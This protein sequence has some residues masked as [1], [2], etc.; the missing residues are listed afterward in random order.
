MRIAFLTPYLPYP[1]DT[2]GKIRTFHILKELASHHEVHVIT[3]HGDPAAHT[4]EGI[5]ELGA[6]VQHFPLNKVY[7]PFYQLHRAL[8]ATPNHVAAFISPSAL[9]NVSK[10]LRTVRFDVVFA[11]EVVMTPYVNTARCPVRILA[12]QNVDYQLRL[13]AASKQRFG[14]RK[15]QTLYEYFR[16]KRFLE[17]VL[18]QDWDGVIICSPEDESV[19]TSIN[20]QTKTYVVPNG[21]DL[22]HFRPQPEP[23]GGPP[24]LLF[25]GS[26]FYYPNIDAVL[27]FFAKIYQRIRALLP[28]IRVLIVGHDP[29]SEIQRLQ[30]TF[31]N[32]QV[33]GSVPDVT[34]YFAESTLVIVPLRLGGGTSLKILEAMAMKRPVVTTSTG[35]RGLQLQAGK[36]LVVAD[37]PEIFAKEVVDLATNDQRRA[38]LIAAGQEAVQRYAW[39]RLTERVHLACEALVTNAARSE[40]GIDHLEDSMHY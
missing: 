32:V 13:E 8:T 7:S 35:C 19:V 23:A 10:Y 12:L 30:A 3:V 14:C 6:E 18:G 11:D 21:V 39:P 34:P 27:Y 24:T 22:Q 40:K 9:E 36:D 2:G 16:L 15:L 29:P 4:I 31:P 25:V 1:P 20:P 5:Q 26:M 17:N 28:T 33:T 38:A 37:D